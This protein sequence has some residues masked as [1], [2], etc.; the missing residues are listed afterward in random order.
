MII[1]ELIEFHA[2]GDWSE[3]CLRAAWVADGRRRVPEVEALI[4]AAWAR[5]TARP[6]VHLFDGPMCRLE[7]WRA[8][9]EELRLELSR[10]TYK[11]FL[12]TNLAHPELAD[13]YG[14]DVLA[15]PV[16]VSP[17]LVTADGWLMMGRRND[18]V[19]YY[20]RRVHPFAGALDPTDAGPFAAV[21]RELR[22]ELSLADDEV[23]GIR[24]TG[25]AEDKSI[26]QP[27][28][29]FAAR[30][31]V[32]RAEI[33]RRLDATEHH[34]A[35]SAPATAG[36]VAAALVS[37]EAFTPVAVA[38]LVLWGRVELGEGWFARVSM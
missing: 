5:A 21:R 10:T 33:E 25:I 12:G 3:G 9:A 23:T 16:G 24:C 20:P 6:G 27:E 38:A 19:A 4:D 34:G 15:N 30:T 28:L 17:A 31:T 37:A 13:R 2:T 7:R 8:T 18:S 32:T 36:G 1:R 14:R 11:A 35:W 26:R 29:I 22:E